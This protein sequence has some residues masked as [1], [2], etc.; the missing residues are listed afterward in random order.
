[1]TFAPGQTTQPVTVQVNGDTAVEPDETFNVN[2][3]NAQGNAAILDGVGLGTI[4]NDDAPA[5]INAAGDVIVSG[6][7]KSGAGSKT[8]TFKVT[9]LGTAPITVDPSSA[10]VTASVTVGGVLTGVVTSNADPATIAVGHSKRFK[11]VW[12]HGV[13]TSG[14]AVVYTACVNLAGDI[15]P[16]N[17]CDTAT[18]K[19]VS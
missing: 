13:L 18:G 7:T 8:F 2:L 9:N 6:P 11:M 17:D 15:N 5:V 3:S 14:L 10:D 12:T 16:L 1:V 4:T 19:P